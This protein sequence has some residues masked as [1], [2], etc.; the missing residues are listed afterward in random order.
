MSKIGRAVKK[1][2]TD[3]NKVVN[4]MGGISYTLNPID[5]L[6]MIA[7]SSIFGEP[8]YYR[9]TGLKDEKFVL[10][11]RSLE[12]F[13]FGEKFDHKSTECVKYDVQDRTNS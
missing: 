10:S 1:S 9:T 4:F 8:Q 5:T 11:K 3:E 2:H 12:R 13:L 7:A 6:K